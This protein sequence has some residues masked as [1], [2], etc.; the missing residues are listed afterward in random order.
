[1]EE[2]PALSYSSLLR[3][4]ALIIA[5]IATVMLVAPTFAQGVPAAVGGTSASVAP[6]PPQQGGFGSVTAAAGNSMYSDNASGS[7]TQGPTASFGASETNPDGVNCFPACTE[8]SGEVT[9]Y[10]NVMPPPNPPMGFTGY[11][12]VDVYTYGSANASASGTLG[13]TSEASAYANVS[14]AL[15]TTSYLNY[16][17]SAGACYPISACQAGFNSSQNNFVPMTPVSLYVGTTGRTFT[18]AIATNGGAA[19]EGAVGGVASASG[20][21]DPYFVIDPSTPDAAGYTLTFSEGI[22]NSPI[23]TPL[24]ASAWL[25]LSGLGGLVVLGRKRKV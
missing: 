11:V 23:P 20:F 9:Y 18:V 7:A 5:S 10:M 17:A 3:L 19:T 13:S 12:L 15:G 8:G 25:L 6:E 21:V 16:S 14:L 24:P 1:M 4:V 2:S 22:G